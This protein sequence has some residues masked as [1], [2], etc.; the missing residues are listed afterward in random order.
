MPYAE[1]RNMKG[2]VDRQSRMLGTKGAL[3]PNKDSH[4]VGTL[5][6]QLLRGQIRNTSGTRATLALLDPLVLRGEAPAIVG[7]SIGL[8]G[9][10][11]S[12]IVNGEAALVGTA[13]GRWSDIVGS[14]CR[15]HCC[16]RSAGL[17]RSYRSAGRRIRRGRYLS[18]RGRHHLWSRSMHN[19]T[20]PRGSSAP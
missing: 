20:I 15:K 6:C 11:S 13:G 16:A 2:V 8:G 4:T 10:V 17:G 12:G 3:R 9:G 7:R 18:S 19:L 5:L 1:R 14:R